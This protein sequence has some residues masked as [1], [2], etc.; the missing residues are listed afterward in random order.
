MYYGSSIIQLLLPNMFIKGIKMTEN[1]QEVEG[2]RDAPVRSSQA[3]IVSDEN[4]AQVNVS[5][6]EIELEPYRKQYIAEKRKSVIIKGYRKG[7][8]PE[9][10]V[11]SFFGD[12]ARE[13][14]KNSIIYNKYMK[15][16]QDHK[17]Q[18]LT[19]PKLDNIEDR[20]GKIGVQISVEVLQP[21]VLGQYL[22]L[23][24]ATFPV[25]S[26]DEEVAKT[27]ESIKYSYPKLTVVDTESKDKDVV[28]VDFSIT[29]DGNVFEEQKALKLNLGL[30][31]YFKEFEDN[32]V[33]MKK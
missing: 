10:M 3:V 4:I 33:G 6:D 13:A 21:I 17:L 2:T 11:S 15:L 29:V 23:E 27:L 8:A 12:E 25:T 24:L 28:E 19:P 18:A 7:T 22:G 26:S 20:D 31:T 5:A 30:G 1:T 32:I 14:A 9:A 16:L